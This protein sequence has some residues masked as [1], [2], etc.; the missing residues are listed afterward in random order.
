MGKHGGGGRRELRLGRPLTPRY[1]RQEAAIAVAS[2]SNKLGGIR[3]A[4]LRHHN[5][6]CAFG[7]PCV[8]T[9]RSPTSGFTKKRD[10]RGTGK[11][12]WSRF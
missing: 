5:A 3:S 6:Y 4:R 2:S 7:G 11:R 9:T 10:S 12:T 8:S 1:K